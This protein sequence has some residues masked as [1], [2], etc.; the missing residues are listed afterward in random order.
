MV[1]TMCRKIVKKKTLKNQQIDIQKCDLHRKTCQRLRI[2]FG[3]R[4]KQS[5]LLPI[6]GA[7]RIYVI[8]SCSWLNGI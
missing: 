8:A 3:I 6:G 5:K 2:M 1:N 7:I 4:E